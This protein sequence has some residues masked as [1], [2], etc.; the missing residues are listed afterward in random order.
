[1]PKALA[2]AAWAFCQMYIVKR[3]FLDGWPGFM[4]AFSSFESTLYK[5]AKLHELQSVRD[6]G[7]MPPESPPLRRG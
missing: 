2:H 1:M 3:G 6:G 4:I 7:W 5:Y